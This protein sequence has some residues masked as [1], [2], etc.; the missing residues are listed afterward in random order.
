MSYLIFASAAEAAA[1]SAAAWRA[2]GTP[3]GATQFLWAWQEHPSDGR[4][5]LIIPPT[6]QG[7]QID[8]PPADYERLLT[9]EEHAAKVEAL[10]GEGWPAAEV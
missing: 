4:A 8:L 2:L 10:P 3:A 1:R 7:A 5:A 6:P 9:A